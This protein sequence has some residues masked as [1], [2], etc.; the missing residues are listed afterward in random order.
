MLENDLITSYYTA[1]YIKLDK[2]LAISVWAHFLL[3]IVFAAVN[4]SWQ[5]S[6]L[7]GFILISAYYIAIWLYKGTLISQSIISFVHWGFA[8]LYLYQMKGMYEMHFFYFLVAAILVLYQNWFAQVPLGL[9][10]FL[11]HIVLFILDKV[12]TI[13]GREYLFNT[14]ITLNVLLVNLLVLAI[15]LAFCGW[16]GEYIKKL[17]IEV[18]TKTASLEKQLRFV[19]IDTDFAEE[20][21]KGNLEV[22]F[23]PDSTDT[24]GVALAQMR[25]GLVKAA[26]RDEILNFTNAGLAQVSAI[27]R[28]QHTIKDLAESSLNWLTRYTNTHQSYLFI[29]KK[30]NNDAFLELVA[31]YAYNRKKY[32]Q[33]K[34]GIGEG[35]A[36]QCFLEKETIILSEIPEDYISITSG[37]GEAPPQNILIVP[38]LSHNNVVGVMELASFQVYESYVISF[39]EK[40]SE[41]IAVAILNIKVQE[42]TQQLLVQSQKQ[43]EELRTREEE[44]RQNMEE[45]Q[46]I[47]EELQRKRNEAEQL[48][49]IIEQRERLKAEI[50]RKQLIDNEIALKQEIER[51]SLQIRQAKADN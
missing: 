16:L 19:E 35:L 22:P 24:L 50:E 4:D 34:I 30:E 10:I 18:L 11:H 40:V 42:N 48:T 7:V 8:A 27:V 45:L 51:L 43:T 13:D 20:I 2:Q 5:E 38:L 46:T 23:T 12:G 33:R 28:E 47:Q 1:Y 17:K 49:T 21:A 32:L 41:I 14:E 37:T 9:M 26:K 15:H 25:N 29:Y 44:L 39:I 3:S 36:G 31:C 6:F